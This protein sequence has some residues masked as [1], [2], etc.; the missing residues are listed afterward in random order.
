[1]DLSLLAASISI[2]KFCFICFRVS[3]LTSLLV[4]PKNCCE[5]E[6]VALNFFPGGCSPN[7]LIYKNGF[8]QWSL[9]QQM[10]LQEEI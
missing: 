8:V 10:Y 5:T 1:M 4:T 7:P 2:F 6:G 9:D 3:S